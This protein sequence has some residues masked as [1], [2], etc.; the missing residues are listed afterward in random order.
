MSDYRDYLVAQ[1]NAEKVAHPLLTKQDL[2]VIV[3][4]RAI[5]VNQ[6]TP[7]QGLAFLVDPRLGNVDPS[8][9][10]KIVGLIGTNPDEVNALIEQVIKPPKPK[11]QGQ[12]VVAPKI[13]KTRYPRPGEREYLDS[14]VRLY[15]TERSGREILS[16]RELDKLII[17]LLSYTHRLVKRLKAKAENASEEL[18]DETVTEFLKDHLKSWEEL[19][20]FS[21]EGIE[22]L[23]GSLVKEN[24]AR[25]G[26]ILRH[27]RMREDALTRREGLVTI[28]GYGVMR[29]LAIP[30]YMM[31]QIKGYE[32]EDWVEYI[33]ADS[34]GALREIE[35]FL[36]SEGIPFKFG[37]PYALAK[38]YG[39]RP[40]RLRSY[41][42]YVPREAIYKWFTQDVDEADEGDRDNFNFQV[43]Y[44]LGL[45]ILSSFD[46]VQPDERRPLL[47][48][49]MDK[50]DMQDEIGKLRVIS[51]QEKEE[52]RRLATERSERYTASA[53]KTPTELPT[54]NEDQRAVSVTLA[55]RLVQEFFQRLE[56]LE[57]KERFESTFSSVLSVR[58]QEVKHPV[59][60]IRQQFGD[61]YLGN[62]TFDPRPAQQS[63]RTGRVYV[64]IFETPI[65]TLLFT[66]PENANKIYL[67]MTKEVN[68]EPY[69]QP[70]QISLQ[71]KRI[72]IVD[73][74][75]SA[76][77][78]AFATKVKATFDA[79]FD[80]RRAIDVTMIRVPLY[81]ETIFENMPREKVVDLARR[82]FEMIF[83]NEN[84]R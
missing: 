67:A 45:E 27:K 14:L 79:A 21:R 82:G 64:M 75:V 48:A 1:Y 52:L 12:I 17:Q 13:A 65:R 4:Q 47:L 20:G 19:V 53:N 25:I 68:G 3:V 74:V 22:V 84:L 2:A 57:G 41:T 43:L 29:P 26:D 61:I 72:E 49:Y 32:G 70:E 44:R 15:K 33:A 24:R 18:I 60:T 46:E 38:H 62:V 56:A 40:P 28:Y 5:K 59:I 73:K 50:E 23:A 42:M 36:K 81:S 58:R 34:R 39:G 10:N 31:K 80:K 55:N 66:S 16:N 35:E 6:I 71:E 83:M 63:A 30:R 8:F 7:E 76:K 78:L 11:T 77:V 51:E 69:V 54:L 37:M 9:A